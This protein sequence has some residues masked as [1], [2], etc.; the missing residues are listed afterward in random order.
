LQEFA[1]RKPSLGNRIADAIETASDQIVLFPNPGRPGRVQGTQE[2]VL[3]G[4][5]F[6]LAYKA[7]AA[8]ATILAIIHSARRWPREF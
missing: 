3:N 5:P 1:R 6:I 7:D 2:V 8:Q 4:T